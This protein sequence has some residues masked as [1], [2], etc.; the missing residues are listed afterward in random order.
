MAA[1]Q[2]VLATFK[3]EAAADAAV[4]ALKAWDGVDDEV[5]LDAIGVLVLGEDGRIKMQKV[6]SRSM[7]RGAGI[8][9]VLA[10]LT[11]VGLAAGL[12]AGGVAGA[13][14]RKGLGLTGA[15]RD[16]LEADLTAGK[17]AVG[18]LADPHE[19]GPVSAKLTELGG[20]LD[21]LEVSDAD[22]AQAAA[23]TDEMFGARRTDSLGN[24]IGVAGSAD[25]ISAATNSD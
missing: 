9:V 18:V 19:V 20:S 21:V 23:A 4:E 22:M 8:G 15:D 3:D 12:I 24:P 13:L 2:V 5:K 25:A 16:R 17:A 7:G 1:K 10:L 11:P 6:G 14:H